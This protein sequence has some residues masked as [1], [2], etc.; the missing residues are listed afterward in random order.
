MATGANCIKSFLLLRLFSSNM[1]IMYGPISEKRFAGDTHP[2]HHNLATTPQKTSSKLTTRPPSTVPPIF[3]PI[4][5][6]LR[7][8]LELFL[9][10][11]YVLVYNARNCAATRPSRDDLPPGDPELTP[12]NRRTPRP[13][14]AHRRFV[15]AR[16][17]EEVIVE[18]PR[19]GIN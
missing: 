10:I 11:H 4:T 17:G 1:N 5:S 6:R 15:G 12:R 13:L 18:G 7:Q 9:S 16:G 8:V 3:G 2:I 19:A 14:F